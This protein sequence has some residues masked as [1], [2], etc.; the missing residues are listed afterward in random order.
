M[1]R[2]TGIVYEAASQ[3]VAPS[4]SV[5]DAM[6]SPMDPSLDARTRPQ[7]RLTSPDGIG[8]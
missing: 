2:R 5:N 4:I 7:V 8:S 3:C 1:P 6:T